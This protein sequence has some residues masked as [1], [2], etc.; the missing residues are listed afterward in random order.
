[1]LR[2]DVGL[3]NQS[4]LT[5]PQAPEVGTAAAH[6]ASPAIARH[7]ILVVS[8]MSRF[9]RE[10]LAMNLSDEALVERYNALGE[11]GLRILAAH[12][13]HQE[14]LATCARELSAEQITSLE[15]LDNPEVG[16]RFKVIIALGGDDFFKLVSHRVKG[17]L[18]ILGV[19]SD[20]SSSVGAL[21]PCTIEQL[22]DTLQR[23]ERGDYRVEPWTKISLRV[24]G[25]ERGS[26]IN[27]IVLG[28]RD[29]RLTSRHELDYRGEKVTQRSSGILISTGVG[30][31]GWYASA[32]R[33][34][35]DHDRSFPK[36]ARFA[37]FELREPSVTCSEVNGKR[38]T[39]LPKL[40]EGTLEE[41]ETLRITSL[42]D[43]EGLA[44]RDSLDSIPF[45]RGAVA[46][47]SIDSNPCHVLIPG[48]TPC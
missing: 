5:L 24:D 45:P 42:N 2:H 34:L 28:K 38:I 22:P 33:Y 19:N 12:L 9:E 20:P 39:H 32:G 23:L 36:T 8:K 46:E 14:A 18:P 26:A 30:S 48:G 31:T 21:L 43:D 1:M 41:G 37:R 4:G 47:I 7:E 44:S 40:V 11:S 10:R 17:S 27:D 35:G 16:P 29:F 3:P 25:V 13:H 6:T 15:G